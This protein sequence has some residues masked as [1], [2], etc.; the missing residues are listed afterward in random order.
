M[1]I[2]KF[3]PDLDQGHPV[4][5]KYVK[6]WIRDHAP[7]LN[8]MFTS[9]VKG[10]PRSRIQKKAGVHRR[11]CLQI[12]TVSQRSSLI[13]KGKVKNKHPF[14]MQFF[15]LDHRGDSLPTVEYTAEELSTW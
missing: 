13:F 15:Y 10:I 12:Q 9:F 8:N 3:D 1:L 5:T 2:T 4:S 7:V 14:V 11:A 6:M